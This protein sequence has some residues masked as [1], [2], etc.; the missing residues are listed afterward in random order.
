MCQRREPHA[1]V[2]IFCELSDKIVTTRHTRDSMSFWYT[3]CICLVPRCIKPLTPT[4]GHS[5]SNVEAT[6]VKLCTHSRRTTTVHA[7]TPDLVRD[8]PAT[9]TVDRTDRIRTF[10]FNAFHRRCRVSFEQWNSCSS[11]SLRHHALRERWMR[12]PR[13]PPAAALGSFDLW[14]SCHHSSI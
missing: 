5:S 12:W 8:T 14:S 10:K 11:P 3:R 7:G 1:C 6:N 4:R 2:A 13:A 9:W